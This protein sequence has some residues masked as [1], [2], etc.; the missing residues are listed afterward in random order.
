[1]SPPRAEELETLRERAEQLVADSVSHPVVHVLEP[2][3][4]HEH[5]A[6]LGPATTGPGERSPQPFV[7]EVTVRQPGQ[8]IVQC[9]EPQS[10]FPA[11]RWSHPRSW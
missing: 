5:H 2:V 10:I 3:Q 7:Q 9:A 11:P 8:G 1:M 4:I 6:H